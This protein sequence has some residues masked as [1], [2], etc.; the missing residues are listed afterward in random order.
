MRSANQIDVLQFPQSPSTTVSKLLHE[1]NTL[2]QRYK[3]FGSFDRIFSDQADPRESVQWS[4]Y[5]LTWIQ[6]YTFRAVNF[7]FTGYP[8]EKGATYICSAVFP[9]GL[10]VLTLCN[11]LF[12]HTCPQQILPSSFTSH[13]YNASQKSSSSGIS[14]YGCCADNDSRRNTCSSKLHSQHSQ[15]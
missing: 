3:L 8:R 5:G 2:L 6:G 1:P 14:Q 7:C 13:T 11:P 10:C 4:R 12:L 15:Q 9:R